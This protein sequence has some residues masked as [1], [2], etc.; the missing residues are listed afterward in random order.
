MAANEQGADSRFW[1]ANFKKRPASDLHDLQ[2]L[3]IA[4]TKAD[5]QF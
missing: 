1:L 3:I 4:D 2:E 5:R